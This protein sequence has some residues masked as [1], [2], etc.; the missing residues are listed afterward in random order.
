MADTSSLELDP[1]VDE[2]DSLSSLPCP[3][4]LLCLAPCTA[5]E[6][7]RLSVC[8]MLLSETVAG[9]DA[10]WEALC[11]GR[12]F[13]VTTALQ[14]PRGDSWQT[15][16]LRLRS[17]LCRECGVPSPYGALRMPRSVQKLRAKT[18]AY[19][20]AALVFT[21]PPPPHPHLQCSR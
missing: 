17:R 4:L 13:V 9:A 10:C 16:Y 14:P 18:G 1:P 2:R 15:L 11:R 20:N 3:L 6:L 7:V 21:Q 19:L 8:S 5:S 12:A